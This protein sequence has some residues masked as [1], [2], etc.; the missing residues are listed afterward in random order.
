MR[1]KSKY[2]HFFRRLLSDIFTKNLSVKIAALCITI[3]LWFVVT[4][5]RKV[6]VVKKVPLNF[7]TSHEYVATNDVNNEVDVRLVGPSVFLREVLD[8]PDKINLDV[9]DKKLGTYSYKLYNDVIKLP[10][11]VKV[12]GFYPSDVSYRIE[13][14][15]T[16]KV[17]VSPSFTGQLP[18]GYQLR[19]ARVEPSTVEVE[20]AES[21]LANLQE[22]YTDVVDLEHIKKTGVFSVG[23]DQKYVS[24]FQRVSYKKFSLY[25]EVVPF[26]V[27]KK[28]YGVKV[29]GLGSKNVKLN[30]NSVTVSVQGS[31]L[32]MEKFLASDIKATIDLSFNAPG[33]Y[34]E[35]VIVKLPD[36]VQLVGVE[37]KKIKVVVY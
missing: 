30:N 9:R 34:D 17:I 20:G 33:T 36:S 4:S 19:S 6:E 5:T 22:I 28:F 35:P 18:E 13:P 1:A 37:P 8:R 11:G 15:K 12:I 27:T 25:V 32:A 16:K 10:L 2:Y 26:V 3:L 29:L 14:I 24:K 23:I 31:K 7:I 21:L